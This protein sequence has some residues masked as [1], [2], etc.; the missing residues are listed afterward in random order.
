[1]LAIKRGHEE[2]KN[3]GVD[4]HV[5]SHLHYPLGVHGHLPCVEC[6]FVRFAVL[7]TREEQQRFA[8]LRL[9]LD[10]QVFKARR[11]THVAVVQIY[12]EGCETVPC[13]W[14]GMRND[15]SGRG[16]WERKR[17]REVSEEGRKEAY[18]CVGGVIVPTWYVDG[19]GEH[20]YTR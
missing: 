8:L 16:R 18:V 10:V 17:E 15:A 4:S 7:V 13:S 1:M 9:D 2:D 11:A 14:G 20:P 6:A 19:S 12:D 5:D 3:P